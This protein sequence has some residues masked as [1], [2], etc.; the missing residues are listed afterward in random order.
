MRLK[1][2]DKMKR[3]YINKILLYAVLLVSS[4]IFS[5]PFIWLIR[6]SLMDT[7]QIF[8]LPPQWIPNPFRWQNFSEAL[9]VYPFGRYFLNNLTIVIFVELGVLLTSTIS[10]FSF[11]R[12]RWRGRDVIFIILLTALMVPYAVT[13][14]PTFILWKFL[15]SIDTYRPLIVPAW[16][17]G[18]IFNIFLLRQFFLTI[19]YELDE[20]AYIDGATPL[21]VLWRI[22]IPLSK[23]ALLT[24]T[25]FT[26][27]GVWGDV[28]GPVIYLNTPTKY[29][30]AVGLAN[31]VTTY[32]GQWNYLMAASLVVMLPPLILFFIGQR[33]FVQGITL[34]GLRG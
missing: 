26:F 10:A 19:P 29:T 6:S 4:F 20:S 31:F 8:I 33:F 16:F 24:V 3:R 32:S 21:W 11:S 13:L 27:L 28:L 12:L 25:I 17:G 2:V 1:E 18:G 9:S 23:P 22:V 14:I 5:L 34:T 30:L 15:K 7:G